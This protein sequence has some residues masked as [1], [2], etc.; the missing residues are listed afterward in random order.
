MTILGRPNFK[1]YVKA[2]ERKS[3]W[4]GYVDSYFICVFVRTT[5][6]IP[7]PDNHNQDSAGTVNFLDCTSICTGMK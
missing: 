3:D 7:D 5:L 6:G 1:H 2:M 4:K